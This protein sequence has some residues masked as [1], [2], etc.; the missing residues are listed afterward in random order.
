MVQDHSDNHEIPPSDDTPSTPQ[1]SNVHTDG[2][3]DDDNRPLQENEDEETS[4]LNGFIVD[5]DKEDNTGYDETKTT[6]NN[7][8]PSGKNHPVPKMGF[9]S[10]LQKMMTR[11]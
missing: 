11:L 6:T 10:I 4:S 8:N 5:D 7:E 9:W 1:P 3:S 2:T